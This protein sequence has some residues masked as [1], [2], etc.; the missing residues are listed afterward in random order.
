[1][2]FKINSEGTTVDGTFIE[3]PSREEMRLLLDEW[4]EVKGI[5][6]YF[7]G[8]RNHIDIQEYKVIKQP[9]LFNENN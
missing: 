3:K 2:G 7:G 1:M 6:S 8:Q 9:E 4:I 5:V